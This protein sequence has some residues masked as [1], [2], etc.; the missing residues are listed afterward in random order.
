MDLKFRV[1]AYYA[2]LTRPMDDFTN[3]WDL[4][5]MSMR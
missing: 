5:E 2:E 1:S 4:F 3:L